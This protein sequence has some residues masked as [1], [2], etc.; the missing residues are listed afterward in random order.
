RGERRIVVCA[1][2]A[3]P[4]IGVLLIPVT[5]RGVVFLVLEQEV[6][7]LSVD[8]VNEPLCHRCRRLTRPYI[9]VGL[10]LLLREGVVEIPSDDA[11][12]QAVLPRVVREVVHVCPVSGPLE[13]LE[14][15]VTGRPLGEGRFE[16]V[17]LRGRGRR[18]RDHEGRGRDTQAQREDSDEE[19]ELA[20]TDLHLQTPPSQL[21]SKV[22]HGTFSVSPSQYMSGR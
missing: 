19:P 15:V 3:C 11:G 17:L 9:V 7:E 18:R 22:S 20:E 13:R 2:Q 8:G 5:D 21:P 4:A 1:E 6:L 14:L 12:V 16:R 10:F